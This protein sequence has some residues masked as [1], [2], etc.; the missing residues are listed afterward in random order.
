MT[1]DGVG[2]ILMACQYPSPNGWLQMSPRV[3]A[4]VTLASTCLG[5][6]MAQEPSAGPSEP[7]AWSFQVENDLFAKGQTDRYYSNG[8]RLMRSGE[9]HKLSA[10]RAG[11]GLDAF[12]QWSAEG[13]CSL[14]GC[15][16]NTALAGLDVHGGQ[17]IY[18]PQNLQRPTANPYDRPY[19]GWLY[20][21]M[22]T[23]LADRP[24]SEGEASRLQTLDVSLGVI[25]PAALAGPVQKAWHKMI[26]A[27]TPQGWSSQLKNEP[28]V[29]ASFTSMH[30]VDLG[31]HVDGLPYWRV[32]IGNVFT[33]VAVG[34]HLRIGPDLAGFASFD[35]A[36]SAAPTIT[37]KRAKPRAAEATS[38]AEARS[39]YLFLGVEGRAVAHNIFVD[40]NSFRNYPKPNYISHKPFVGDVVAGFSV[41]VTQR[42]RLTYG[43]V[44]RSREFS[45][46]QQPPRG[47]TPPSAIQRYGVVQLQYQ[48]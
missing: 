22:R 9:M 32:A 11:A 42:W 38:I 43:H 20:L 13:I 36:P 48:D 34:G 29:Q 31:E 2:R 4:L 18:T 19:A 37:R 27:T 44:W 41:E 47:N 39:W 40:G 6:A 5:A 23:R 14:T 7:G 35:P 15:D 46:D 3:L 26:D 25:G 24:D 30:R 10:G 28:T 45:L 21:G 1:T 33:H 12:K 8:L 17:N 16:R